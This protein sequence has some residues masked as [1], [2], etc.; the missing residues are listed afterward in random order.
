MRLELS[1]F[2]RFAHYFPYDTG[3]ADTV[4]I[5]PE[6]LVKRLANSELLQTFTIFWSFFLA[7]VQN[8][9]VVR[10][11]QACI[12]RVCAGRL[13]D[14]TDYDSLPYIHGIVKESLRWNPVVNLSKSCEVILSCCAD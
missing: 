8:P 14:F 11:A 2:P 3:G 9:G 10:K 6:V 5:T 1:V 7:M 12:D 13:P 4:R